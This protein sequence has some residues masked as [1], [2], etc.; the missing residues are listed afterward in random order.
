M[1][2]PAPEKNAVIPI[3]MDRKKLQE[4][5]INFIIQLLQNPD[6]LDK[7]YIVSGETGALNINATGRQLAN[8]LIPIVDDPSQIGGALSILR[9]PTNPNRITLLKRESMAA[10]RIDYGPF[11][12]NSQK[13]LSD[14]IAV[15]S[16]L[17]VS[18]RHDVLL[19]RLGSDTNNLLPFKG[20]REF[21]KTGQSS[22]IKVGDSL[23]FNIEDFKTK[24][25]STGV[26]RSGLSGLGFYIKS[27]ILTT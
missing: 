9:N 15:L 5:D 14:L 24:Q 23:I 27:G 3:A 22:V 18:E 10:G 11:D 12:I 19:S 2:R 16:T 4:N 1:K 8:L 7:P 21:F 17:S 6:L 26:K 20:L 25:S 13:G